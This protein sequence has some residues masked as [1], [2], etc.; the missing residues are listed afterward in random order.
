MRITNLLYLLILLAHVSFAQKHMPVIKA[1]SN[2]VDIRDGENFN[3]GG[4]RISPQINPDI[5][6]TS[7]LNKRVVFYTDRDSISI[8]VKANTKFDFVILLNDSV[9]AFTQIKYVP[10]F[11]ETLKTAGKYNIAERREIPQFSYQDK[12]DP[13]LVALRKG[14]KL[15]SVAGDGNEVSRIINLLHWVHYLIPHDGQHDNPEVKNAMNMIAVCK[16]DSRGLN[17]R[18]LGTVLNECYLSMGFKSRFITCLP[19]DSTDTECHVINMVYSNDLKK[20]LWMDP[21]NDAYVMNEK[22]DLLSI[23][24]VRES[25]ITDKP[26]ILNPEANWNRK[27]TVLKKDYL[28]SYMAKN[29]YRFD[30]PIRSEYDTETGSNGKQV[31][32]VELIPLDYYKQKPEKYEY[33][34]KVSGSIIINYKTNNE[35]WFWQAP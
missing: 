24:E 7:S 2:L 21:T 31:S 34:S 3:K 18:G 5:Y 19:K 23:E 29:L 12:E 35:D 22:G 28:Y 20:W 10:G 17:C 6:T 8:K 26:L 14:F 25:L 32:Y 30:C 27:M 1:S 9:K 4:W 16:R 11:Q 13:S 33:V 15:D